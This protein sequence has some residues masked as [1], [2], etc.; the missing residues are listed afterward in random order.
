[1]NV[2]TLAEKAIE[3]A[4]DEQKQIRA[5]LFSSPHKYLIYLI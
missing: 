1:M 4:N 3:F 5:H 2:G